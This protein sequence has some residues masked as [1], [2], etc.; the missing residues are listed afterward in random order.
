M[1]NMHR[2][3]IR[4]SY[5]NM[6]GQVIESG[7]PVIFMTK[8]HGLINYYTGTYTGFFCGERRM[9]GYQLVDGKMRW[10]RFNK[11]DV[12][13]AFR[14]DDVKRVI[15]YDKP[16]KNHAIIKEGR[17]F[18]ITRPVADVSGVEV[19]RRHTMR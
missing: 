19:R 1:R 15:G 2:A 7:D 9:Q 8:H 13:Y 14:V 12:A 18:K 5:T 16:L 4:G 10:V 3:L 6:A 17:L 11:F